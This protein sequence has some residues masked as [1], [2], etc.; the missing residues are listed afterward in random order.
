GGQGSEQGREVAPRLL[1]FVAN[2]LPDLA[3]AHV[4]PA[5]VTPVASSASDSL[6]FRPAWVYGVREAA[7]RDSF[8]ALLSEQNMVTESC[9]TVHRIPVPSEDCPHVH[10]GRIAFRH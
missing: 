7:I 4:E 9:S 2:A 6:R 5:D 1:Q 3:V 10:E 8:H